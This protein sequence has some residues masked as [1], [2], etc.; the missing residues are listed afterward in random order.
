MM[1]SIFF[2]YKKFKTLNGV[3]PISRLFGFD[4]GKPVDRYY[5]EIFLRENS[6][7]IT[8]TTLEIAENTYSKRFGNHVTQFEVLGYSPEQKSATIIGDLTQFKNLPKD[9]ID[10]FIC[11][12]TLNFI[13]DYKLAI[14]GIHSIL[15]QD[16]IALV[17]VGGIS[18][19]SRYDA[20]RWGDFWRFNPQGI[21]KAFKEIFGENNVTTKVF[22][23]SYAATMFL[24][25]FATV[26]CNRKKLDALDNDYPVIIALVVKKA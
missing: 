10:C 18:Q 22:G 6:Q 9:Y 17:T 19:I 15:K 26:D 3:Q 16:G 21:E 13:Y 4:R 14:T 25:G 20:D 23:N 12:Q 1:K 5:I 8:G 7:F 2:Y 11:T 24:N